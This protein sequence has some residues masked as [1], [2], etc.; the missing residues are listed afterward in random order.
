MA[1]NIP[2]VPMKIDIKE[3][4]GKVKPVI[5][6]ETYS[7]HDLE[8]LKNLNVCLNILHPG[9]ETRG[10]EHADS[11]EV[12]IIMD[13]KGEFQ[14]GEKRFEV[15]TGDIILVKG[16]EFHKSFNTSNEDMV[17]LTIFEKYEGRGGTKPVQYKK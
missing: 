6:N 4:A 1:R 10:H 11:D 13:G 5:D 7:I 17:F 3:F 12:Y 16:G 8:Y 15:E 14:L 2:Q 9:K